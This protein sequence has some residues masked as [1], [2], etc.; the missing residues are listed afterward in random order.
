ML[1]GKEEYKLLY[2]D[3]NAIREIICNNGQSRINFINK[4]VGRVKYAPVFSI[5]N[6][7]ELK[8]YN[9]IYNE[10]I[11]FFSIIPCIMLYPYKNFMEAEFRAAINGKEMVLDD[12]LLNAFSALGISE[13]HNFKLFSNEMWGNLEMCSLIQNE[14]DKLQEVA[15]KW[16]EN[17]KKSNL[18]TEKDWLK[19]YK[20]LE[21]ETIVKDMKKHS[22]IIN[23]GVEI[24]LSKMPG[25]R[26]MEFSN[27]MRI[28][29]QKKHIT[30][31]DVMD[32][33]ISYISPYVDCIITENYQ[34]EILKKLRTRIPELK[35]I[36][37]MRLS[38][39]KSFKNTN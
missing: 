35:N 6:L 27:F 31:N 22:I 39:L 9:D 1:I 30:K 17:K 33:K 24:D 7:F 2:L 21:Y 13:S 12:T 20:K 15:D 23:P 19:L 28:Y 38:E 29:C 34:A 3:T 8:P 14:I 36:E 11:E 37:I 26:V 16:N 5:Y 18:N 4:I 32:V 10:F 25:M